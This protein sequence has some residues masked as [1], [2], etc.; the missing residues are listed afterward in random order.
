MACPCARRQAALNARP[1]ARYGAPAACMQRPGGTPSKPDPTLMAIATN[2]AMRFFDDLMP[3]SPSEVF[4][5]AARGDFGQAT[6]QGACVLR[7][8]WGLLA[9]VSGLA[10]PVLTAMG[11]V[12]GLLSGLVFAMSTPLSLVAGAICAQRM[13]T[14][15]EAAAAA[16]A[17]GAGARAAGAAG[18][19]IG[20][21]PASDVATIGATVEAAAAAAGKTM[22]KAPS[23][24][25]S[26]TALTV[27]EKA[28]REKRKHKAIAIAKAKARARIMVREKVRA[29]Q[30]AAGKGPKLPGRTLPGQ[31]PA[32][33]PTKGS[34]L[35]WLVA[36]GVAA[37]VLL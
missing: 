35:P 9:L 4:A 11:G 13:P 12:P 20:D 10:T 3:A 22:P 1:M 27:A 34:A 5:A 28:A 15:P 36:L 14:G 7:D 37:K 29:A 32:R 19:D 17:V 23:T 33:T 8:Y 31:P 2:P 21:V 6:L 18:V 16:A 30:A 26:A 24:T 25:A